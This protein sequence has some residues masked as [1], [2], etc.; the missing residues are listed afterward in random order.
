MRSFG[1]DLWDFA[2]HVE[3]VAWPVPTRGTEAINLLVGAR[4]LTRYSTVRT[5]RRM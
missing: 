2:S 5:V 4:T 1:F 3:F